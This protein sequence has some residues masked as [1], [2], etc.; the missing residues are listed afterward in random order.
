MSTF[1]ITIDGEIIQDLILG[2]RDHAMR[3]LV[4]SILNDVLEAEMDEHLQADR[5]ERNDDRTGYRNG[6]YQRELAMRVGPM[7]LRVP[8]DR[9]GT[10]QTAIFDRYQRTEK[11]LVLA[12]MEMVVNGVSTR[13]VKRITD[14]LCGKQFSKSTVSRLC[15]ALDEK[16]DAWANRSL[17]NKRYP[18]ILVDAI[19]IKVR[20]A[21]AIRPTSALV[22][23]GVN[24]D[25]YREI[26]GLQIAN[27]E[28]NQSWKAFFRGLNRR[29]LSGVDLVVSDAHEGLVRAVHQCFQ[30]ATWQ[31]CQTH[32]RR[33]ILDKTP[34]SLHARMSRGL[35]EVFGAETIDASKKALN[36]LYV[37]LEHKADKALKTLEAGFEDATAVL[38]LPQKYR[39]RLRTTNMVERLNSEIRRRERVIRIFPNDQSALRLIGAYLIEQHE[40]WI[41]GTRYF[42]MEEYWLWKNASETDNQSTAPAAE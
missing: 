4:E 12:L 31:R 17:T 3:K 21:G 16:V 9:A 7:T 32:F 18:F 29:G 36:E 24:D 8:R 30:G 25:G 13:K 40:E 6:H 42:D 28:T 39:I 11:A 2:D 27:S 37:D 22:A 33:N 5:H 38:M 34:K 15:E 10:F 26:L 23:L 14:E 20:R 35:D 41:T 1:E 19:Q